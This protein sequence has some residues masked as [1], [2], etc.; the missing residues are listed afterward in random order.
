MV[1]IPEIEEMQSI[2]NAYN[3]KLYVQRRLHDIC[4][5][6]RRASER[7]RR[8]VDVRGGLNEDIA[9]ILESKGYTIKHHNNID[10]P[11]SRVMW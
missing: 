4:N 5:S 2:A 8:S 7:G 3:N 9:E 11:I 10:Y 1:E 6:I